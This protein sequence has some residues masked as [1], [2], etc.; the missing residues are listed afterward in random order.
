MGMGLL[1][2]RLG[3]PSPLVPKDAGPVAAAAQR[4]AR[5]RRRNRNHLKGG[6]PPAEQFKMTKYFPNITAPRKHCCNCPWDVAQ[7]E[8]RREG[9]AGAGGAGREGAGPKSTQRAG[10]PPCCPPGEQL[11]TAQGRLQ[12]LDLALEGP[13]L[14]PRSQSAPG[15]LPPGCPR[16]QEQKARNRGGERTV[17]RAAQTARGRDKGF[18]QALS[19]SG[20][21]TQSSW[22]LRQSHARHASAERFHFWVLLLVALRQGHPLDPPRKRKTADSFF[23]RCS[24]AGHG[25]LEQQHGSSPRFASQIPGSGLRHRARTHAAAKP[26]DAPAPWIEHP[27]L[28]LPKAAR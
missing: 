3:S 15:G 19:L 27:Q 17:R 22:S 5:G 26:R 28:S 23:Q 12:H 21:L 2:G 7:P 24:R 14:V 4:A 8:G 18:I 9:G 13:F 11:H 16:E 20:S 6:E 10:E 25:A 1:R